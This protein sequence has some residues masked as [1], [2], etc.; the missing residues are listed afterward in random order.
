[1]KTFFH[2]IKPRAMVIH[3][4]LRLTLSILTLYG[5]SR[6]NVIAG[7]EIVLFSSNRECVVIGGRRSF[8]KHSASF[9]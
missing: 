5:G 1:M 6:H 4:I 7:Y 2:L 8:A 3:K 9:F